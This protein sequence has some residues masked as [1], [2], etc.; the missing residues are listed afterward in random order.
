MDLGIYVGHGSITVTMIL[1]IIQYNGREGC[2][3]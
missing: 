1:L 2:A 3:S